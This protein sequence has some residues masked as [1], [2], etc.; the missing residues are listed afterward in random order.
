M[1][2]ESKYYSYVM[3]KNFNK[4]HVMT[5]KDNENFKSSPKSWICDNDYVVTDIKVND[6][7]HITGKYGGSVYRDCNINVKLNRKIPVLFL[8]LKNYDSCFIMQELG[9]FDLN[10]NV[11]PDELEKNI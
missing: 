8:S 3:K 11:I 4:K 7:C 2:E 10:I 1:I 9:K 5:N 6:H